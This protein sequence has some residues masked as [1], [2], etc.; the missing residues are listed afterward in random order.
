MKPKQQKKPQQTKSSSTKI[1][2]KQNPAAAVIVAIIILLI[3]VML[4]AV[5][6]KQFFNFSG[7]SGLATQKSST[8]P[9]LVL[10]SHY[11]DK[12]SEYATYVKGNVNNNSDIPVTS[13]AQISFNAL[14][15]SGANVGTCLANI[16][17]V[18][19]H[20][21]W[22]FEAYC[23]GENISTVELDKLIGY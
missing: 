6:I 12:S 9:N 1:T 14:D 3:F 11:L 15:S 18:K 7:G 22:K 8:E 5:F 2:V 19:A 16:N 23:S 10:G 13:Y 20:G 17:S 4:G 21:A